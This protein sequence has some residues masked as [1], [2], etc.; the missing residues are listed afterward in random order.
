M[1][2]QNDLTNLLGGLAPQLGQQQAQG[3]GGL[4]NIFGTGFGTTTGSDT[5]IIFTDAL[6]PSESIIR[7]PE[8]EKEWLRRR[9]KETM[10]EPT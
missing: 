8:T 10:W 6:A 4:G 2:P 1:T 3:L 9:V 5:N 7:G